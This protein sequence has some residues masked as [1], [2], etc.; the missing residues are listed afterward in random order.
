[1]SALTAR[2]EV[3]TVDGG[4][5][6]YDGSRIQDHTTTGASPASLTPG[7]SVTTSVGFKNSSSGTVNAYLSNSVVESL[8]TNSSATGALY[9]YTLTYHSGSSGDITLYDS[10]NVGGEGSGGL[11]D[12]A[13]SASSSKYGNYYYL[14]QLASGETGVV[15]LTVGL[16]GLTGQNT[17]Q[18]TN[19]KLAL[20]F[21]AE[22]TATVVNRE[23]EERTE[24][25]S[26]PGEV[27]TALEDGTVVFSSPRTSDE[28][29]LWLFVVILGLCSLGL[30]I[31][32][33]LKVFPVGKKERR[34][35]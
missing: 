30:G 19:A 33:A 31:C 17:Y 34:Q 4:Y 29:Q 12:A 1:M 21:A 32:F 20:S 16:D 13:Q 24:V 18:L 2:A 8:E 26:V 28:T 5:Y 3:S 7:S 10:R 11:S 6:S 35:P 27:V 22:S 15:Y 9:T 14:G 25:I 23:T